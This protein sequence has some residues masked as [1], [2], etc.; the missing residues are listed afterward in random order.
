MKENRESVKEYHKNLKDMKIRFLKASPENNIPDY[1]DIIKRQ[2]AMIGKSANEY[3]LDLIQEDIRKNTNGLQY[4]D[5]T[6]IRDLRTLKN[7]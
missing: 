7:T 5:F 3:I 6:I 2:A 1:A 4:Q